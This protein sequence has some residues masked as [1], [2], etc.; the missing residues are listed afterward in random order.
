MIDNVFSE[1]FNRVHSSRARNLLRKGYCFLANRYF[2]R[3][4]RYSAD[5]AFCMIDDCN[6]LGFEE[7]GQAGFINALRGKYGKHVSET[8]VFAKKILLHDFDVHGKTVKYGR[9]IDWHKD[10]LSDKS[11]PSKMHKCIDFSLEHNDRDSDADIKYSWKLNSHPHL[12]TL[13]KAFYLT[14]NEKYSREF[15]EELNTWMDQNPPYIGINWISNVQIS[16][17]LVSWIICSRL[18]QTSAYF[19]EYGQKMLLSAILDNSKILFEKRDTPNNNHRIA[20]LCTL[21]TIGI[22]FQGRHFLRE[23]IE[24]GFSE[25]E[26][27]LNA[28]IYE[29]G[30]D[31]EQTLSYEKLV[32]EFLLFLLVVARGINLKL[33]KLIKQK[34]QKIVYHISSSALPNDMIPLIGDHSNE[35]AFVFD[36]KT[37][38]KNVSALIC[39]YSVLFNDSKL[40]RPGDG[41]PVECFWLLG[42]KGYNIWSKLPSIEQNIHRIYEF[43]RGGHYIVKTNRLYLFVRCGEFGFDNVNA[44]SHCD[45]LSPLLYIDKIPV[46]IDS[47]TYLYNKSASLRNTYRSM[48]SHNTLVLDNTMQASLEGTFVSKSNIL[49]SN[50]TVFN[51]DLFSGYITYTNGLRHSRTLKLNSRMLLLED[52]LRW[53]AN[54]NKGKHTAKWFFNISPYFELEDVYDNRVILHGEKY[55]LILECLNPKSQTVRICKGSYSENYGTKEEIPRIVIEEELSLPHFKDFEISLRRT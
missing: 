31:K 5:D 33:P 9:K 24:V 35:R 36:E 1:V 26:D 40:K 45:L 52:R 6:F 54:N 55:D 30:V 41:F 28:Q 16:Q 8:L 43:K 17:R 46:L 44:H 27:A 53:T 47:G 48:S 49:E 22:L 4:S 37:D 12:V 32:A 10:P 7:K 18:F 13:G 19:K 29:D 14:G 11:W 38:D 2:R 51:E 3:F 39:A 20:S 23:W 42:T 25:L 50:C 21:L 15:L 34:F